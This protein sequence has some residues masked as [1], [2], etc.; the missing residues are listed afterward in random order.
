MGIC[1]SDK[2]TDESVMTHPDWQVLVLSRYGSSQQ[3]VTHAQFKRNICTQTYAWGLV[4]VARSFN[5]K[6]KGS[7]A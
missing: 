6:G 4:S 1:S 5:W 2:F 3:I 7:D